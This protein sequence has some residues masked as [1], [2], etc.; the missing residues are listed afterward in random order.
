MLRRQ[1][2]TAVVAALTEILLMLWLG[3]EIGRGFGW[4]E[5]DALFRQQSLDRL[6]SAVEH[7]RLVPANHPTVVSVG[8]R[9][10]A[11]ATETARSVGADHARITA[12]GASI[13][14]AELVKQSRARKQ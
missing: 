13:R 14:M 3:Y 6:R 10:F 9:L 5:M 12:A 8:G 2:A 4:S 11:E 1:Q 7:S